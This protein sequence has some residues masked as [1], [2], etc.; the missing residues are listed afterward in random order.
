MKII[1][2]QLSFNYDTIIKQIIAF[3][4]NILKNPKQNNLPKTRP[5]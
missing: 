4:R 1:D 3:E 5:L 2:Y